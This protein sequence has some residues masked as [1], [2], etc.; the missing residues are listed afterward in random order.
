M[1]EVLRL[2][3]LLLVDDTDKFIETYDLPCKF[4]ITRN[5]WPCLI[6]SPARSVA[7]WLRECRGVMPQLTGLNDL[8]MKRATG[9]A[10]IPDRETYLMFRCCSII[11][12]TPLAQLDDIIARSP[13]TPTNKSDGFR[14]I[15]D[16]TLKDIAKI[17]VD[18]MKDDYSYLEATL[19]VS[20]PTT[21]NRHGTE[22]P[23]DVLG[24]CV[25]SRCGRSRPW[26]ISHVDRNLL[27]RFP[28]PRKSAVAYPDVPR[29]K[30]QH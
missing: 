25:G 29:C 17:T 22:K 20:S 1:P 16:D 3:A 27:I 19:S 11:I 9:A 4:T 8:L 7:A 28:G 24:T 13:I 23:Q 26:V 15:C 21:C 12:L 5:Y 14:G 2:R 18:F 30:E 6:T 10:A